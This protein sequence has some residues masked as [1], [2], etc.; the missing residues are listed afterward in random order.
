[1]N[2][3]KTLEYDKIKEKLAVHALSES[4]KEMCLSLSPAMTVED[5]EKALA[6]FATKIHA[7]PSGSGAIP[8]GYAIGSTDD[9]SGFDLAN[10]ILDEFD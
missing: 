3:Y 4:G 7:A 1:M 10:D 8:Y 9:D 2:D 5:A 6:E